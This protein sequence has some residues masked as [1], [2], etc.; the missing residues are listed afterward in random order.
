M[1]QMRF[2]EAHSTL[3][4]QTLSPCR[5]DDVGVP[6]TL[7]EVASPYPHCITIRIHRVLGS[8]YRTIGVASAERVRS[9]GT[10]IATTLAFLAIA[11]GAS[12]CGNSNSNPTASGSRQTLSSTTTALVRTQVVVL[13]PFVGRRPG[14]GIVVTFHSTARCFPGSEGDGSRIDA[15][16]CFLDQPEPDGGSIADPCFTDSFDPSSPLLCFRSPLDLHAV[17]V[18]PD[19][20]LPP[21]TASPNADPWFLMLTNR[22]SCTFDQGGT[23]VVDNKRLN[24]SCADGVVYGDPDHSQQVWK[25]FYQATGS[26]NIR[27]V[28]IAVA[29]S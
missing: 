10:G 25:V 21:N 28:G 15:Y 1:A 22:Q 26:N 29:Y 12:A 27:Q 3:G 17:Q 9:A 7:V 23:V 20:K 18:V 24:Y 5:H 14:P 2:L 16:R 6:P 8:V 19:G 4:D 13:N 11:L